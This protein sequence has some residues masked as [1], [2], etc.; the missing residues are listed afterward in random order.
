MCCYTSNVM[1]TG[2]PVRAILRTVMADD[3]VF[4]TGNQTFAVMPK[5]LSFGTD[6][7]ATHH[8]YNDI[9]LFVGVIDKTTNIGIRGV[10]RITATAGIGTAEFILT[11]EDGI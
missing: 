3:T 4:H 5:Q 11:N 6:N 9:T 2:D 7:C 10:G 1:V 8:I